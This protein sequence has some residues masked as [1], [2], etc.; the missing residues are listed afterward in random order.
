[1]ALSRQTDGMEIVG[2]WSGTV[3]VENSLFGAQEDATVGEEPW[4][5]LDLDS[6]PLVA[7]RGALLIV[8]PSIDH[9][10]DVTVQVLSGAPDAREQAGW[11]TAGRAVYHSTGTDLA[12]C[13]LT[14]GFES[15]GLELQERTYSVRLLRRQV[16][17]EEQNDAF[18]I[19]LW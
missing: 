13:S 19:Q 15:T 5:E 10:A 3:C 1:M 9:D 6:G 16:Q 11:A 12:V 14:Q 4:T 2:T 17:M 18:L 7:G 8:S